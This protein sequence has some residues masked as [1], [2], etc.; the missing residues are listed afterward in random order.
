MFP[1]DIYARLLLLLDFVRAISPTHRHVIHIDESPFY[2]SMHLY[3]KN[4]RGECIDPYPIRYAKVTRSVLRIPIVL[5]SISEPPPIKKLIEVSH[6]YSPHRNHLYETTSTNATHP[7]TIS[8][9]KSVHGRP[10][11]ASAIVTTPILAEGE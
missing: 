8:H 6:I 1:V 5:P 11:I 4:P 7:E 10:H 3:A 2:P 9:N